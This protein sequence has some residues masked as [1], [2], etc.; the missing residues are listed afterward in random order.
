MSDPTPIADPDRLP[1]LHGQKVR[2]R[3][4]Y[5]A[6]SNASH[7]PLPPREPGGVGVVLMLAGSVPVAL[8]VRPG[9]EARR[10]NGKSV[11]A[12]GVLVPPAPYATGRNEAL[13]EPC[14][15]LAQIAAIEP[16]A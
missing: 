1:A 2:M 6:D 5:R 8:G 3:G 9:E 14:Y 7:R 11:V 10:L 16:A 4:E 15:G 12:S 13:P